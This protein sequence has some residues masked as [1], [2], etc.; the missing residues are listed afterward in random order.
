MATASDLQQLYIGYFGRAAD[1]EGLN[2]WVDAINNGGL[3]LD[4]VHTSFVQSAEY[5]AQYEGLTVAAKVAAVYE[6]VL[7][8]VADD[9]GLAFWTNAIEAGQITEDQLIEGL[10]SGLSANDAAIISNKVIVAN[11]YTSAKGDAYTEA[12][13]TESRD[14]LATVD[15][16]TQSVA[17]ALDDVADVTG[18]SN[19]ELAS[20]LATLDAANEAQL[21]YAKAY[22]DSDTGTV[23]AA[24]TA[25]T[26]AQTAAAGDLNT[27]IT[28]VGGA[29]IAPTDAPA[30]VAQKIQLA[31]NAAAAAVTSA[32]QGVSAV[33]GL[34]SLVN[35]FNSQLA[36]FEAAE[37]AAAAALVEQNSELA[38]FN[39]ING[40]TSLTITPA[41]NSVAG[42]IVAT[43]GVLSI[44]PTY[45]GNATQL[46]AAN[47]L[48]TDIQARV[49]ADK[50]LVAANTALDATGVKIDTAS[51]DSYDAASNA[52][53][54]GPV[55]DLRAALEQQEEL[56][57][58]IEAFNEAAG[59][60]AE[61][62]DLGAA[63][64]NAETAIADLGYNLIDDVAD[65][66][67]GEDIFVVG[68]TDGTLALTTGDVL[69]VG[70]GY[71]LGTDA[72]AVAT[73][74]QGGDSSKLEVFFIQDGSD[75]KVVVEDT[76]F[77][78]N[79]A[80]QEVTT[81][82]VTGITSVDQLS[83]DAQTGLITFA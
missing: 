42:V 38:K 13:K 70:A 76:A 65:A 80:A 32:Q 67:S 6:N 26:G 66:T 1:Q 57:D 27:E 4:N 59:P 5:Q 64:S 81:I 51:T 12:S 53:S 54:S 82:T 49:A 29:T 9:E 68:T 44:D 60:A 78:T 52:F 62:A 75:I 14:I 55:A 58:A 18:V 41:D 48:L 17:D 43:D 2:F 39:V 19:A 35:T 20:A 46:A 47:A 23:S 34:T 31:Q 16:S 45:A 71:T 73:G 8:R 72:D 11:Y 56:A 30:I 3:S 7:G 74:V 37:T 24:N 69:F 33:V 40:G 63:I 50:A 10:L 83:F 77:G 25:I 61:W 28:A 79:A 22:L 21:A 36:T 15:G